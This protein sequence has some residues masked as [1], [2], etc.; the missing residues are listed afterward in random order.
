M[1]Y[2]RNNTPPPEPPKPIVSE[3]FMCMFGL[4]LSIRTASSDANPNKWNGISVGSILAPS[5]IF[6]GPGSAAQRQ[7]V[8]NQ[9]VYRCGSSI[10]Q[11]SQSNGSRQWKLL[12]KDANAWIEIEIPASVNNGTTVVC[13]IEIR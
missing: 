4:P 10:Q 13:R 5:G 7:A 11:S 2:L 6:N 8:V 12:A 3:I 1:V 9:A